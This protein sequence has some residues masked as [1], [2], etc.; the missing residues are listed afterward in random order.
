MS[1]SIKYTNVH[2]I[3]EEENMTLTDTHLFL[4]TILPWL[5]GLK[6]NEDFIEEWDGIERAFELDDENEDNSLDDNSLDNDGDDTSDDDHPD[7][8]DPAGWW[9]RGDYNP[10]WSP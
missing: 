5:N 10:G 2:I 9:K 4:V 1:L 8:N 6:S 7:D 3:P